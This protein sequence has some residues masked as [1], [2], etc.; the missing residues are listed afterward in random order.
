MSEQAGVLWRCAVCRAVLGVIRGDQVT[1][2]H[3]GREIRARLP[4]T[5]RCHKCGATNQRDVDDGRTEG[6]EVDEKAT[7]GGGDAGHRRDAA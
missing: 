4:V 5:Q 7:P 3:S 1:I 6:L 2:C